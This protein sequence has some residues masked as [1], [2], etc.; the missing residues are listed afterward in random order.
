MKKELALLLFFLVLIVLFYAIYRVSIYHQTV[1]IFS[2]Y[3]ILTSSWDRYKVQFINKNGRNLDHSQHDITTSE[4][5]SYAMLRAVWVD[6][7]PTFDLIWNWTKNNLQRSDKL[8]GWKWGERPDKSYGFMPNGGINSASD[9]DSDIALALILASSRWG[10][11]T[12]QKQAIP[13]LNSIWDEETVNILG[14]RY[15]T[16]GNWATTKVSAEIDP[17]YFAPYSWRIF[18]KV[19]S[20]H[21]WTSLLDP[22][23]ELLKESGSD[24]L[25]YGSAVGLPPD[26]LEIDRSNGSLHAPTVSNGTT[27]YSFD[28]MRIP[29]RIE[30]DY[31]WNHDPRDINYLSTLSFLNKQ[32]VANKKLASVYA[33]DGTIISDTESP[34]MYATSLGFFIPIEPKTAQNFYQKKVLFFYS[35]SE[36]SFNNKLGYYDQNW[37]WFGTALYNH[38]LSD[39]RFSNQSKLIL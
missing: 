29:W 14:R 31:Q 22:A 17:S 30:L 3:S 27:N 4:G 23:F 15:L 35:N 19:D 24:N 21:N 10:D 36:N 16:A 25:D 28:A 13:I 12:Y 39:F 20:R 37:L 8:F 11:Q 9:A 6:D 18:S 32:Y 1:R 5:Q 2:P 33:H 38:F 34:A 7:K 26:W